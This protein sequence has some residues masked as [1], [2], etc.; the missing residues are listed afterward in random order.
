MDATELIKKYLITVTGDD[1][2]SGYVNLT[3]DQF[4]L[5][6]RVFDKSTWS[7]LSEGPYSPSLSIELSE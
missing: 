2:L 4:N 5:V 7:N 1:Y 6:R 3:D